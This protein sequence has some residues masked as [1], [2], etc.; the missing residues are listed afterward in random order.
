DYLTAAAAANNAALPNREQELAKLF[1]EAIKK[2]LALI[3]KYPEFEYAHAARQSLAASYH[4]LGQ[5]DLAIKMLEAVPEADRNG[6]LATVSYLLGDCLTRTL[7]QDSED[8][9]G[10]ARLVQMAEK[11]VKLFDAFIAAEPKS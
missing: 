4:Q 7:P 5:F 8:A 10:A 1:G 11:A 9:L 6:K 3:E 2:H